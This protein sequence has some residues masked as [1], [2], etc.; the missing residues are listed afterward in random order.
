MKKIYVVI[1][2]TGEYSDRTEWTVVAY[3]DEKL[4]QT[5]AQLAKA[6]ADECALTWDRFNT[7]ANPTNMWDEGMAIDYT[8]TDYTVAE[9]PLL[10]RVPGP[11]HS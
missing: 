7:S 4:A 8:G 2:T 10:R 1:G 9:V 3:T 11:V 5:H 6:R